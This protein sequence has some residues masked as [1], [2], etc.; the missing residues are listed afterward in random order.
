[1]DLKRLLRR[2]AKLEQREDR[3]TELE[4]TEEE[5]LFLAILHHIVRKDPPG[6]VSQEPI[7]DE[8]FAAVAA[9]LTKDESPVGRRACAAVQD[10]LARMKRGE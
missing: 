6:P 3:G 2:L 5:F 7:T 8:E 9:E 1:M 4:P 10:E